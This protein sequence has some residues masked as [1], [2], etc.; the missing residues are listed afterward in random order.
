MFTAKITSVVKNKLNCDVTYE[1]YKDDVLFDT[2]TLQN[3][4][5]LSPLDAHIKRQIEIYE[6]ID[7]FD[8][9]TIKGDVDLAAVV[10]TQEEIDF[11]NKAKLVALKEELDLKLII[12]ADYD[13]ELSK[14][15]NAE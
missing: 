15:L 12:Q 9:E 13:L 6:A 1:I 4:N 5:P 3:V 7:S 10:P 8:P 14:I 11:A 2:R